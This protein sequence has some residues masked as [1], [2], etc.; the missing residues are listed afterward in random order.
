M[1]KLIRLYIQS[2]AIG[3]GLAAA[4]AGVLVWQDVMGVGRLIL[5]SDMGLVALVML[6][7]FNGIIFAGVQFALRVM[8]M[9]ESDDGPKGGLRQHVAPVPVRVVVP[10]PAKAAAKRR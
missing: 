5:G 7:V 1:P 8:M 10:A 2:V 3:F 6:I 9:A 4:F